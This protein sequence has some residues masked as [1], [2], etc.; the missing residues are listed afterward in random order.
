MDARAPMTENPGDIPQTRIKHLQLLH[1]HNL[2]RTRQ[3]YRS[4]GHHDR[5]K[6]VAVALDEV[7]EF[8]IS[9]ARDEHHGLETATL[10]DLDQLRGKRFQYP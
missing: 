6:A 8:L 9:F 5:S 3:R 7:G 10:A 1:G 2:H 4:P